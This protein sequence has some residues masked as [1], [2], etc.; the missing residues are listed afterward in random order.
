MSFSVNVSVGPIITV[1]VNV[2]VD[3][4]VTVIFDGP[5]HSNKHET[6]SYCWII[7]GPVL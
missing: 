2:S 3:A 5:T 6:F 4:T 7:V 1:S